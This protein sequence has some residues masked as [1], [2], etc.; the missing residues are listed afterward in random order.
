VSA[1]PSNLWQANCQFWPAWFLWST[2][3][4]AIF[5][6]RCLYADGSFQFTEILKAGGFT[7]EGEN[8]C[9]VWFVEQLPVVALIKLGVSH[10]YYLQ[11]AFG[12]GCF[13]PW[14]VSMVFCHR[15]ASRHFWLV[16]LG[17]ASG[18]LNAA[19]MPVGEYIIAH[20]FFWPVLFAVMFVRPLTPLAAGLMMISAL[21]LVFSY[22][23]L[24]FLGPPLCFLAAERAFRRG[25][26]K[27]ARMALG[28]A[29]ALLLL[30]ALVALNSV[31]YPQYPGELGGFKRGVEKM[32]FHPA[33]TMG[34]TFVWLFLMGV[35]C[36]GRQNFTKRYF[37]L[38][39]SLL[40]AAMAIWGFWPILAP[41]N[42]RVER[43]FDDRPVQLLVSLA[44]LIVSWFMTRKPKWFESCRHYLV[45]F[46]ASLLLAQSL[47][48]ITA[49]W[50]WNGFIG[51]WRGVLASR[52]GAVSLSGTPLGEASLSGQCLRFDW[53]WANPTLSIMLAPQG[54][55]QSVIIPPEWAAWQPFNPLDPS[56][57]PRLQRY[58]I[59]Y[60]DYAGVILK[61]KAAAG[62]K[63]P[64][65]QFFHLP[66]YSVP[67]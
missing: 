13:L 39:L 40:A 57:F 35:V 17:C 21:I 36:L 60:S 54:R 23:S 62:A 28:A 32:L 65:G 11:L 24:L 53:S 56:D 25:E 26:A 61:Q 41:Y 44:L 49:T 64:S 12:L 33:W 66:A 50:Q 14:L 18:Y 29:A 27:W 67:Q 31:L 3:F 45:A 43:Q 48:Q 4:F 15:M 16:M 42:L 1:R 19:F 10:L 34:W 2:F 47:W 46:S 58:G 59:D 9:C 30:A 6:L 63:L 8:R 7:F 37:K 38:K 22:E 51:V 20:A 5:S 55:V 52:S